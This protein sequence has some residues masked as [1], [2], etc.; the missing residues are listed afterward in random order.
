[1]VDRF[2]QFS[3]SIFEI[4][5]CWHNLATQEMAR[6]GLKGPYA[7]YLVALLEC[8]DGLTAAELSS[9]CGRDKADVS[10]SVAALEEKKLVYRDAPNSYRARLKLT[11][12]GTQAADHV[13]RRVDVAVTCAGQGYDAQK[14]ATFY[15][16]LAA[17]TDNLSQLSRDGLP[18]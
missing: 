13:R 17:I 10:R 11:E 12:L 15:E 16:V 3:F 14:R 18:E 1:M 4:Y 2:K 8:P 6:Y 9:L 5:R 7:I